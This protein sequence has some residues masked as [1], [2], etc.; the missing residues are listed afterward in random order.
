LTIMQVNRRQTKPQTHRKFH[1][2]VVSQSDFPAHRFQVL[3]KFNT[4]GKIQGVWNNRKLSNRILCSHTFT[5]TIH[6]KQKGVCSKH[7]AYFNS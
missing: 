6:T 5:K 3:N 1:N 4:F 7:E 2:L